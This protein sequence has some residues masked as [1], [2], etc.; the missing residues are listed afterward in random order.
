MEMLDRISGCEDPLKDKVDE[1]INWI[2]LHDSL[3][4]PQKR[5]IAQ[6]MEDLARMLDRD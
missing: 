5:R 2:N 3:E 6:L 4:E 1:I